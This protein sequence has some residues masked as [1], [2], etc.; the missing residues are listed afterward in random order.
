MS[1]SCYRLGH[2][3]KNDV[4]PAT[5]Q[6]QMLLAM[7]YITY[8]L[9]RH[10]RLHP[11]NPNTLCRNCVPVF[12]GGRKFIFILRHIANSACLSLFARLTITIKCGLWPCVFS[13]ECIFLVPGCARHALPW[14][15]RFKVPTDAFFARPPCICTFPST[16]RECRSWL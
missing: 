11:N 12:T 2:H 7:L 3:C 4:A 10:Q 16:S 1:N 8:T 13:H 14:L 5:T 6:T 9:H 15:V